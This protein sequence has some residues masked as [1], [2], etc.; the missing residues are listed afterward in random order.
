MPNWGELFGD[1]KKK[2]HYPKDSDYVDHVINWMKINVFKKEKLSCTEKIWVREKFAVPFKNKALAL[3][4]KCGRKIEPGKTGCDTFL[5]K[6]I[7]VVIEECPC[8]ACQEKPMEVDDQPQ[9]NLSLEILHIVLE[10]SYLSL[11]NHMYHR[12]EFY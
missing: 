11:S 2:K 6:T 9:V 1:L 8:D 7:D 10:I 5:S 3:W 4:V 12:L